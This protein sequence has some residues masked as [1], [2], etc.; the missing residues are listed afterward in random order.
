M[1]IN[2]MQDAYQIFF[3]I[4]NWIVRTY[5]MDK[6]LRKVYSETLYSCIIR[7]LLVKEESHSKLFAENN[8]G[9]ENMI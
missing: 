3:L 1:S 2:S 8:S 7:C 9:S 6:N 5:I 4:T